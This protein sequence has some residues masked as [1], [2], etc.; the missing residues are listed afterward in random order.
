MCL[1]IPGRIV[2]IDDN[3]ATVDIDGVVIRADITLLE[4]L[5]A[6]DYV[7]VHAG[8]AIQKYDQEDAEETLRLFRELKNID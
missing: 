2:S 1:A 5:S 6:G 8:F 7:L 3:L 4:N